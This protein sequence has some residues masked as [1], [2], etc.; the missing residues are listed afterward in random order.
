MRKRKLRLYEEFVPEE[1]T[2]V[3][4]DVDRLNDLLDGTSPLLNEICQIIIMDDD[5]T[6]SHEYYSRLQD[7]AMAVEE[8]KNI[9]KK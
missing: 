2:S 3:E 1:E 6:V 4:I 9:Y 7:A 5:R 8:L